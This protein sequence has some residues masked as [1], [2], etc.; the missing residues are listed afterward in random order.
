MHNVPEKFH[1][2]ARH[3]RRGKTNRFREALIAPG[4]RFVIIIVTVNHGG[5]MMQDAFQPLNTIF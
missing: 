2:H 1:A 5:H 3:L 4:Y